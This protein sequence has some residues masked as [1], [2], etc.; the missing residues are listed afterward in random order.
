MAAH[1]IRN[2]GECDL[3]NL[4]LQKLLYLCQ[5]ETV[6]VTGSPLFEDE[7]V[8][9]QSG[10]VVRDVYYAYA[11]RGASRL[12]HVCSVTHANE[13]ND[14]WMERPKDLDDES[15]R[16]VDGVLDRW[17]DKSLWDITAY[18]TAPNRAWYKT[19]RPYEGNIRFGAVIRTELMADDPGPQE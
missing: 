16:I 8:A 17:R 13:P 18:V 9:W 2:A 4:V 10:P 1:L 12:R 15:A 5:T 6:R 19:Y 7:I 11:Y 3:T 14:I